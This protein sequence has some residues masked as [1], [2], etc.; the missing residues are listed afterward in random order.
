[1]LAT[2]LS[3]AVHG[4]D[5][6]PVEV[7]VD[8]TSGLPHFGVVGLPEGAVKEG[9]DRVR[10][11]VRNAGFAFPGRKVIVNLAPADLKK[12][13]SAFD[14]PIALGILAASGQV[15]RE[16]LRGFGVLGEL[17]LDGRVKAVRG[18]LPIAAAARARGLRGLLLPPANV[19][20]AAVV[21][22]LDVFAV[23]TLSDAVDF[24]RGDRTLTPTTVDL[25]TIFERE[26][27]GEVDFA[28]VKGQPLVKRALEVAAAGGHNVIMVGPPGSGKT[29]LAQRLATIL[30]RLSLDEA[31][32][33]TR[34]HSVLGLMRGRSL[35]TSRPFRAPHHTIS[36]AGLIGGGT[37][38]RP[39]EVSL[40]H[41]GVLFLDELP[42]FRK[43][44]LE[45][46]RQPLEE[47]RITITRVA[48]SVTFPADIMLVAAMN[49]CP[50]GYFGDSQ[51]TCTC[52]SLQ[53]QRYRGRVSG[54]LLDRIDIHVEVRGVAFRE[55]ADQ[56]PGESSATVRSRVESAR[57][58]QLA[59]F[60]GRPLF[61]NAQMAAR[62]VRRHAAPEPA[63]ER[64]LE[65]AMH[66]L[67]LSARA[68]SRILKVARTIADLAGAETVGAAHVAEAV[69]YRSLDRNLSAA[70]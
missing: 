64:L 2:V 17:S 67:A 23:E 58:N 10:S 45:V 31:I 3:S 63:A 43:N 24:L 38:P 28:D 53:V 30:P 37:I 21:A 11:A 54:P 50:C 44:V 19:R 57:Q 46:L 47:R 36:D 68:Y 5:G 32:E 34:V 52:P 56:Q 51:R 18:A 61:C 6:L 40:A 12:E 15:P 66:S 13:G 35:V 41:R 65:Q 29:M 55:L 8:L 16:S 14:L 1:M 60:A 59:R 39:G 22:G 25:S 4:V 69:Q 42:E 9:K 26:R 20:E 70:V 49:P 33:A 48:G 7:E 62:D 27:G